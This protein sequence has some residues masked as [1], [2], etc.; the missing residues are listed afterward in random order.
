MT[1][2][3]LTPSP[4]LSTEHFRDPDSYRAYDVLGGGTST[5]LRQTGFSLSRA[6]L[7]LQ[8]G[9]FVLQRSFARRHEVNL[10]PGQGA[11]LLVPI[12]SECN[13]NGTNIDNSTIVLLRGKTPARVIE[14]HP[15]TYLML[16]FHSDMR[17]RGWPNDDAALQYVHLND[18]GM[19]R[20]R[21]II[22][23]TFCAA[24]IAGD[25]IRQFE[26]LSRPIRE[27]FIA[28][29][30][31][32]LI[33]TSA[34]LTRPGAYGK[35]RKIIEEL[36]EHLDLS[37]SGPTYSDEL[38]RAFGVSVR[39]LQ[40]A[41]QMVHGMSLH[42]YL[43]LKRMWAVRKQLATGHTG[44]TVKAAAAAEGFWHMGQFSR[45]YESFFGELP[46]ETLARA[47]HR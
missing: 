33:T 1:A 23:E 32:A 44:L 27:T 40:T 36:D 25:G 21:A 5:P 46:S 31:E 17:H 29:L 41:M 39:T 18:E 28:A 37:G 20:L 13:I 7:S 9:I 30:D 2:R 22:L 34:L 43:R 8:D 26:A 11:G 14:Q 19:Q 4:I 6:I 3:W 45:A 16:R 35:Y 24:S 47:Q 38:A 15:N 10:G 42:R 12:A